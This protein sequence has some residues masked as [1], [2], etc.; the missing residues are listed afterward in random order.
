MGYSALYRAAGLP[1]NLFDASK[2][3]LKFVIESN[4]EDKD[5]DIFSRQIVEKIT[6]SGYDKTIKNMKFFISL[7][8]TNNAPKSNNLLN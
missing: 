8:Q 6:S 3:I 7:I 1:D 2:V 5:S 4:K